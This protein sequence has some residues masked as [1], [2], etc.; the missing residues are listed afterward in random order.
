MSLKHS[1]KVK[2]LL[3]AADESILDLDSIKKILQ[4]NLTRVQKAKSLINLTKEMD[5][6]E[7]HLGKL[8]LEEKLNKVFF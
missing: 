8:N 5:Q 2:D 4:K 6:K 1:E 3:L 7:F